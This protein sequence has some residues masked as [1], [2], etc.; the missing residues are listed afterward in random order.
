VGVGPGSEKY[1][2][3]YSID[4][5]KKS[6]Y[7]I[8]YKYTLNT[9]EHI[10]DRSFN[11]VFEVTMKSQEQVYLNVFN[12]LMKDGDICTVPFTGDV[13]FSESEVV[14]R[15]LDL[16]GDKNVEIV[17]GVSSIQIASAK[18]RVPLDKA[19][20]VSFHVTGDIEDKKINLVKSVVD[21]K[22]VILVPRPWPSDK[23]KNFMPSEISFFLKEKGVDT[24]KINVWIFENLTDNK[25]ENTYKGKLDSLEGKTFSDLS[26]MVIDQNKRQTYLEF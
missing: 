10:L 8:G 18:S 4:I 9:I 12:D 13:N 19:A 6:H 17:P 1:L 2:T 23:L 3:N 20:I 26:V 15:L 25:K 5:I 16:F 24:T 14:D 11:H 7:I 22:S 21:N